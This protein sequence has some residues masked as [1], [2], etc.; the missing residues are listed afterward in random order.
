MN[1]QHANSPCFHGV[2]IRWGE[3]RRRCARCGAT[4]RIRQKKRGRKAIRVSPNLV[5]A[6]LEK[7]IVSVRHLA[8]RRH[9]GKSSA[10]IALAKSLA[11]FVRTHKYDWLLRIPRTG[12]LILVAD[13]IW[14]HVGGIKHTIYVLM[15]RGRASDTAVVAPPI[16]LPGHEDLAGWSQ[17][18]A[19]LPEAIRT[20][21]IAIVCD[22]ATSLI[23][24][25]RHNDWIIQRCH[26]HLIASVQNYLT[27]GPRSLH[28]A[29]A[30]RVLRI[31]HTALLTRSQKQLRRALT[32]IVAM[33][34]RS[35][36]R[37]LR[38][39]LGGLIE[40]INEHRTYLRHPDLLLPTTS[41]S[42]ESFIQCVRDLLYRC[43]GFK[44]VSKLSLW[45]VALAIHKKYIRCRG[46]YQPN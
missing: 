20:R 1:N 4:W 44:N 17:A 13:A 25:A 8:N 23:H 21:I 26:F 29:F 36:S 9:S 43:R 33:R 35:R 3:R 2:V 18:V 31:V 45:I 5:V 10:Q 22:G 24:C 19:T 12:K 39:V 30:L 28:R 11:R 34:S 6:Y 42:A 37:G 41:N 27:T 16:I 32:K 15:L 38:R 40:H 7:D 14:Y 46:K